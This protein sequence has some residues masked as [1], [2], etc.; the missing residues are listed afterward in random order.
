MTISFY[1]KFRYFLRTNGPIRIKK[2][3]RLYNKPNVF[4]LL[5]ADLQ[6]QYQIQMVRFVDI[7]QHC[8]NQ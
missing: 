4:L 3:F 8:S 6:F 2:K 5:D 7:H 1:N